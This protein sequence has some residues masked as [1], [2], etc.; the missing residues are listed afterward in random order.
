MD[1][2]QAGLR[3]DHALECLLPHMGLRGRKRCIEN[4]GVSVNGRA[5]SATR[6]MRLGDVVR[7]HPVAA[8]EG[9][10]LLCD[11]FSGMLSSSSSSS[12]SPASS[13]LSAALPSAAAQSSPFSSPFLSFSG[14]LTGS[15]LRMLGRQ[16]GYCFFSKPA[17]MHS[18]AL[19]G[20][21]GVSVEALMPA[22]VAEWAKEQSGGSTD[23]DPA[24]L[25]LLQRLDFG[26]SGLLCA[27]LSTRAADGFRAAEAAG[28]CEKRYV[29]LLSGALC[30][31]VV[32]RQQLDVSARRKSRL[33]PGLADPTRWTEFWPLHVWKAGDASLE[34]LRAL[35]W[36]V[37]HAGA[38]AENGACTATSGTG[39]PL[40]A[41]G[42]PVPAEQ[43]IPASGLTLAACRI[44]RGARHQ[45]RAHAAG[46][47]H[48]LWGDSLYGE[49]EASGGSE[50]SGEAEKPGRAPDGGP[51]Q[52]LFPALSEDHAAAGGAAR[53]RAVSS[54]PHAAGFF[55][56]HGGLRLPDAAVT[57]DP[58]WPLPDSLM[59]L[60]RNWLAG[61]LP[62][63]GY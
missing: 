10:A 41:R 42:L 23:F 13:P 15:G 56:H 43:A 57:D 28:Q 32:A 7:L 60:V 47:G 3:L 6:R 55:L 58:P 50:A 33:R 44:R 30:G 53:R 48:A 35:F 11:G 22:L 25:V 4:G 21:A 39:A 61:V 51:D 2:Q 40:A 49:A 38:E 29:A 12:S 31:P 5:A 16:G 26:T 8:R 62:P 14:S 59:Q 1:E 19:A 20:V 63:G 24:R 18:A 36:P 9:T 54:V 46:L 17:L 27:A 45:I 37:Q 52:S 34:A